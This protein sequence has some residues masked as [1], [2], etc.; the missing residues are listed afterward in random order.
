MITEKT[1]ILLLTFIILMFSGMMSAA[2]PSVVPSDFELN[3]PF[4]TPDMEAFRRP[5]QIYRPQTWF[6]YIGGNVSKAGITADLEAIAQT[7]ISGIQL[8]H[9][10]FGGPWPGV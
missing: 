10:Q 9:G 4:G 7:G 2:Q 3:R 6:H 1:P 8:F 5:P